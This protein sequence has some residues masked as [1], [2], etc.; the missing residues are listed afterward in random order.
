MAHIQEVPTTLGSTPHPDP[1][2]KPGTSNP[3]PPI[4]SHTEISPEPPVSDL[5][6]A[7]SKLADSLSGPKTS[8]GWT[9]V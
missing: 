9:K 7:L 3:Q 8:G 6:V 2:P 5:A 1:N 4:D